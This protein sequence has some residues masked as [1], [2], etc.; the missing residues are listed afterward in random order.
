MYNELPCSDLY[1]PIVDAP[2][3]TTVV[4]LT[5]QQRLTQSLQQLQMDL[6][7]MTTDQDTMPEHLAELQM[8]SLTLIGELCKAFGES[9][10]SST[11]LC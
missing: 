9:S 2:G 5:P 10:R 1:I 7:N 3:T 6:Y 11:G 4:P 8:H